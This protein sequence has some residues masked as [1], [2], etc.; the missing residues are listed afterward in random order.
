MNGVFDGS[1][2]THDVDTGQAL[3]IGGVEN[4]VVRNCEFRNFTNAAEL[5]CPVEIYTVIDALVDACRFA[6]GI[7]NFNACD[8]QEARS[9]RFTNNVIDGSHFGC[10]ITRVDAG[11]FAFNTL[12]GRRNRESSQNLPKARSVRGLKAMGCAAVRIVS[13]HAA[14]YES[15][16]KVEACFRYD[17]S[18][19]IIMNAGLHPFSGQIALNVG[20]IAHG[21]NMR[22]GT[23]IGN[24]VETCGGT[25]IGVTSDAIGGV[26]IANN[27][28]RSTQAVAIHAGVANAQIMGNRIEDWGLRGAGDA[29]VRFGPGATLADNRFNNSITRSAACLAPAQPGD[30]YR[31]MRDNVSETSNP[32][33]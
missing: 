15:P 17:I 18:H 24:Q 8:M 13:N 5:T 21:T 11:L 2:S 29:A 22:G 27:I 31:I 23:I 12:Q 20:S 6:G 33:T 14:D 30:S 9:A 32:L 7:S 1:E 3:R 28:V 10:N 25:G 19:N 4:L 26:I 16:V